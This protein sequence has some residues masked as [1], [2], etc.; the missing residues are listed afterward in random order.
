MCFAIIRDL[1]V[2][3]Q[4]WSAYL[5]SCS[6]DASMQAQNLTIKLQ[7]DLINCHTLFH[8]TCQNA[9]G[10]NT[11]VTCERRAPVACKCYLGAEQYRN[12]PTCNIYIYIYIYIYKYVKVGLVVVYA[13]FKLTYCC[14]NNSSTLYTVSPHSLV[15]NR[16][17]NFSPHCDKVN[18]TKWKFPLQQAQQNL[19][20]YTTAHQAIADRLASSN[21]G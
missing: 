9:C 11:S 14:R 5:T 18:E 2:Y 20:V 15:V 1:T 19:S 4:K 17:V 10:Q 7:Q 6:K 21:W 3:V 8:Q 13:L 12:K 16:L